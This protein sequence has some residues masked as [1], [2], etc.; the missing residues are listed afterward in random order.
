MSG[1]QLSEDGL[2]T[3]LRKIAERNPDFLPEQWD[4]EQLS[5]LLEQ[6]RKDPFFNPSADFDKERLRKLLEDVRRT[7][8]NSE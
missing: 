1:H 4:E 6:L 8:R 2:G 5:D 3:L 7:D